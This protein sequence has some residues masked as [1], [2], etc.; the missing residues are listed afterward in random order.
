[1]RYFGLRFTTVLRNCG[2]RKQYRLHLSLDL[3]LSADSFIGPPA[4]FCYALQSAGYSFG[5]FRNFVTFGLTGQADGF[6]NTA[7]DAKPI[8]SCNA[9]ATLFKFLPLNIVRYSVQF[10]FSL[11]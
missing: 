1:L 7:T 9:I 10:E 3:Q 2:G 4:D 6:T 5:V 11:T 8:V